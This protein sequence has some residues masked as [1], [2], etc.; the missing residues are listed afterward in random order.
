MRTSSAKAKG[1]RCASDVRDLLLKYSP[2]FLPDDVSVTP[3]GVTGE[4]VFLSPTARNKFNFAIECKNVEAINIWA[5]YAQA[6][7]HVR[8]EGSTPILFFKRNRSELMVCMKAEDFM[9]LTVKV[10]ECV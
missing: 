8:H 4:D 10:E 6:E 5:S 2:D 7:T 9:K 3:S 1:R